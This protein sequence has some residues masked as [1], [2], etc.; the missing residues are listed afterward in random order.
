[1]PNAALISNCQTVSCGID[2]TMWVCDGKL[3]AAGM[4]QYGQLGDGTD[5]EY[6]AKECELTVPQGLRIGDID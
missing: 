1:M 6:N 3:Y 2:F 4:P 5:H